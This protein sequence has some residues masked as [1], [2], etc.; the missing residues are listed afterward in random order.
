MIMMMRSVMAVPTGCKRQ[1][2][3]VLTT[4]TFI[5]VFGPLIVLYVIEMVAA[6]MKLGFE[7]VALQ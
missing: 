4:V 2:E 1:R 5:W 7:H 3:I 6:V